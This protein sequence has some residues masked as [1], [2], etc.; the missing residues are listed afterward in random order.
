M[1][2]YLDLIPISSEINLGNVLVT[3]ALDKSFPKDLLVAKINKID[4]NDQKPFQQ[5]QISLF[6][7]VNTTDNL[8]VITNYKR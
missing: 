4:K 6:F 7:N 8:F 2:A 5:A 3:S 1:S